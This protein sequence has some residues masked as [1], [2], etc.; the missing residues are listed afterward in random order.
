[1]VKGEDEHIDIKKDFV[2]TASDIDFIQ[3][4][5]AGLTKEGCELELKNW[6][7]SSNRYRQKIFEVMLQKCKNF[8]ESGKTSLGQII[9]ARDKTDRP[10]WTS[11]RPQ[12][13]A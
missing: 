8:R 1:M 9:Y 7:K 6:K 5:P 13:T 10:T 12:V 4:N 2:F 3:N 11:K